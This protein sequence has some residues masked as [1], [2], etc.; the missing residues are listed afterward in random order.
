MRFAVTGSS[1]FVGRHLVQRLVS[2][3]H[4]VACV[5]RQAAPGVAG[6]T[7]WRL[8]DYADGL[9]LARAFAGAQVVIHLAARAHAPRLA[10]G[11]AADRV[12]HEANV[13]PA[14][15]AAEAARAAGC[16]RFVLVSSI[17]VNGNR[18]HG[19]AFTA[20]DV[21]APQEAYA[22]SKHEAEKA[23][24]R[25]LLGSDTAAVVL[26]PPLVYGPGCPGNFAQ[27]VRLVQN[28]PVV[29][30]GGLR[31]RRSLIGVH[32]LCNALMSASTHPGCA[33]RAFVLCDGE[34]VDVA[35]LAHLI[36][37]GLGPGAG[38]IVSVPQALLRG[39][40]GLLGRSSAFDKLAGELL[41]D[42]RAFS[43]L[44]GWQA[45]VTLADGVM[46]TA[47]SFALPLRP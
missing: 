18:T 19:R 29:P 12:W 5:S 46:A 33:G 38:R 37:A 25:L 6:T 16:R 2:A 40:A 45:A 20:D 3:G 31:Q 10:P 9:S 41:V 35:S 27:L 7:A 23:V 14:V 17:G 43:S 4:E 21:P 22:R 1:G 13:L 36:A 15:A 24:M 30:L 11:P 32:H 44:T 39:A 34:D 8:N 47:R 26:R 28:W 42:G